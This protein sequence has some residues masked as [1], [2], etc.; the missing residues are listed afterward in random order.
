MSLMPAEISI[1]LSTFL[2]AFIIMKEA[3]EKLNSIYFLYPYKDGII[4]DYCRA[5]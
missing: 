2:K 1:G 5:R 3:P 4:V